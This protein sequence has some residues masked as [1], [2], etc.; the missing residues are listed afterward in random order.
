[1]FIENKKECTVAEQLRLIED[2]RKGISDLPLADGSSV[3][4]G[5]LLTPSMLSAA[6]LHSAKLNVTGMGPQVCGKIFWVIFPYQKI[7][8]LSGIVGSQLKASTRAESVWSLRVFN[9]EWYRKE[10]LEVQINEEWF[11]KLLEFTRYL[12]DHFHPDYLVTQDLNSR[13]PG[14]LLALMMGPENMIIGMHAHPEEIKR[15]LDRLAEIFI[16]VASAQ[17]DLIPKFEGGYCNQWGLWSHGTSIRLQEDLAINLSPQ[18]IKEF[19]LPADEKVL[20]KFDYSVFHTHSAVIRLSEMVSDL[21]HVRAVEVG[22][23]PQGPPVKELL[24][25]LRRIQKKKPL[26]LDLDSEHP[27]TPEDRSDLCSELSSG[28]CLIS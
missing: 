26:V 20:R 25:I 4:D 21:D 10:T 8:W 18:L 7:S 28:G 22:I 9:S 6:K 19:L 24:P 1:M 5:M 27:I 15:L 16:T 23:D 14:D 11:E 2:G 3:T 12:V 13:G 17:F